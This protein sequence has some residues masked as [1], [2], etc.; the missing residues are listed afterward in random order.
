MMQIIRFNRIMLLAISS[1]LVISI[2]IR[3]LLWTSKKGDSQVKIRGLFTFVSTPN[4]EMLSHSRVCEVPIEG[5]KS[6]KSGVV[7]ALK[8]EIEKN[9][10][11]LFAGDREEL[12]KVRTESRKWKNELSDKD[13]LKMTGNCTLVEEYFHDN[14]YTTYKERS[15]PVAY[16]F[17]VYDSSQQVLRLL[18][19]LYRPVNVY[20]IHPD[21]KSP[22]I[23]SIFSNLATCLNNIII[24]S[25]VLS[26]EWGHHS[27]MD[28]QMSCLADLVY[29]RF[30]QPEQMRWKYVINLCGKELPLLSTHTIVT[31][32]SKL[33]G[34]SSIM[35][36]PVRPTHVADLRRLQGQEI[37][38][39]LTY[40]K[41]MT[42][43][44]LS[45]K[46]ALFLLTNSTA[47]ELRQF[48]RRSKIPEE[49]YYATVYMAPGI[50]GGF[51][52]SKKHL[53]FRVA[54]YIWLTNPHHR[55]CTGMNVH[56][57]C[58]VTVDDLKFI[59]D[60]K[61]HA[62]FH[63]K[64]FMEQDHTIMDCMEQKLVEENKKE[65]VQDCKISRDLS[66]AS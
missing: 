46:F 7:T 20:C 64:Y 21:L 35:A 50:P 33:N 65:Y 44:A 49:H 52:S 54:D 61:R 40:Y 12:K 45:Y 6:W 58:I 4:R 5:F 34:T 2:S 18:K 59:T 27:I 16:T 11:K 43:M 25:N 19:F 31:L 57:I 14:L 24:P 15:F 8:P 60:V 66:T 41:S 39:N 26:V 3:E 17:V 10:S 37:P 47:I 55:H 28:A 53:L 63:N 32:L 30:K 13:L 38:Y 56:Y 9:C 48:F 51:N 42:Y 62:L 36:Y 22:L 29:W 1:I 23:H